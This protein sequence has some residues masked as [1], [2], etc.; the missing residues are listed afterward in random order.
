MKQNSITTETCDEFVSRIKR[1]L[2]SIPKDYI[3]KTLASMPN[4]INLIVKA[5]G[6]R[7]KN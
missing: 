5:K 1:S 2:W 7:M 3:D 6:H 4:R